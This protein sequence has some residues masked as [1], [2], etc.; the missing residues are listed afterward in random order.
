[1]RAVKDDVVPAT[2][3]ARRAALVVFLVAA[4]SGAFAIYWL[5][6]S[7]NDLTELGRSDPDAALALFKSRVLPAFIVTVLVGVAGGLLLMRQGIRVLRAGEFPP[8]GMWTL[9][10][11]P[12]QRGRVAT[13]IGWLLSATGFLLAAVP[14]GVLALV[15]WLLRGR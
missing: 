9:Q 1:M 8:P 5:T 3:G 2:P 6:A 4:T 12:R 14:L 15:L 7:L 11:T 10:D 13:T